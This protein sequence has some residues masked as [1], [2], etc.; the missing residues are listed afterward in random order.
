MPLAEASCAYWPGMAADS[1]GYICQ[2]GNGDREI[3]KELEVDLSVK[4]V[5]WCQEGQQLVTLKSQVLVNCVRN[6][7]YFRPK[8]YYHVC[9]VK[10]IR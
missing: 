8:F 5:K 7:Y 3:R 10:A 9:Y 2:I 4:P 1:S 6:C